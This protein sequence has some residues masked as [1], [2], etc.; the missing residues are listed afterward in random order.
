VT[1]D[2]EAGLAAL[3]PVLPLVEGEGAPP[4]L[5]EV[6][7]ALGLL[8]LWAGDAEA[9]VRWLSAEAG[10]TDGGLP[11][12]LAIRAMSPLAMALRL[13]GRE[14]EAVVVA[15]RAVTLARERD[16]PAMLA[17]ALAVQGH[18]HEALAI[19]ADH[20]LRP[21][22][23]VSLEAIALEGTGSDEQDVRLFAAASA[24]RA[25]IGLPPRPE[26][27]PERLR[28]GSDDA[29]QAGTTLSL[30]EAADYA[31]RARGSRRRPESGWESLTTAEREVVRLAVDGLT[32]PEIGARL[33]MSR[34]T[35]KTHLSH[36]YGKLGVSNRTEL[37]ALAG[38]DG[39]T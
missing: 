12:Y 25:A 36:V 4:F 8:H 32:N 29:W 1:G 37:A 27:L 31:R 39:V 7:R 33:F 38:A 22:V 9:A 19:R 6:G 15:E 14:D 26:A 20:G 28:G 2:V 30:D 13:A 21:G 23:V 18:H 11:T 24:A 34:S 10:S 3:D 5:P 17:A 16:M 35:V